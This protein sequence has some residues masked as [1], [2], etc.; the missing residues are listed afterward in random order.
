MHLM[1]DAQ[2]MAF[3]D[4]YIVCVC[5][6]VAR[7]LRRWHLAPS[8]VL[9]IYNSCLPYEIESNLY[10]QKQPIYRMSGSFVY[11]RRVALHTV[12]YIFKH[13][14]LVAKLYLGRAFRLH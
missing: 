1:L 11:F 12:C 5:I 7:I 14:R 4:T 3:E 6:V 9:H 2:P 10:L 8:L 13:L